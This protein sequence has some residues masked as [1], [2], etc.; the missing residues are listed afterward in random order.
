VKEFLENF[1]R[2]RR[3]LSQAHAL[4]LKPLGIGP[5]QAAILRAL[6]QGGP[7][8]AVELA[9]ATASDPAAINRAVG[10]LIKKRLLRQRVD[11]RDARR[12]RLSLTP[13]SGRRMAAR[14]LGLSEE[15]AR[16]TVAV[17]SPAE[18]GRLNRGLKALADHVTAHPQLLLKPIEAPDA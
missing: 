4:G 12:C 5:L 16:A 6:A 13:G 7:C 18:L 3:A 8:S 1:V 9:R 15:L 14:T 11:P 10:A 17:L 2:L